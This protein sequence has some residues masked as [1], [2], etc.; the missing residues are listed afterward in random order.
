MTPQGLGIYIG[1]IGHVWSPAE[2]KAHIN[3]A[4]AA[5]IRH[6]AFL[7]ESVDG[8]KTSMSV[9][10][11]NAKL[12]RDAGFIISVYSL[13]GRARVNM[14]SDI[15]NMLLR[16]GQ[17]AEATHVILDAEEAYRGKRTA[18]R[19]TLQLLRA[20]LRP[21]QVLG[22]TTYG[23]P[24]WPGTYPWDELKLADWLGHQVYEAAASKTKVRSILGEVR[25]LMGGADKVVPHL[26]TYPRKTPTTPQEGLEGAV[27]LKGD[28]NRTCFDDHDKVDCPGMWIWSWASADNT[29]FHMLADLAN[30]AGW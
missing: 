19:T 21:G 3:K 10:Q 13:P 28:F 9:L 4:K 11:S 26:A 17:V 5:K 15:A 12:M 22:V 18:L 29:E 25:T 16:A 7:V 1:R 2:A 27:R 8:W 23:R 6:I 30:L 24:S 20:G 14:A